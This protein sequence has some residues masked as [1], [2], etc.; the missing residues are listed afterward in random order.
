MCSVE[1][2]DNVAQA[3]GLSAAKHLEF[4]CAVLDD[5]NSTATVGV[6]AWELKKFYEK[7][8]I[9]LF[10]LIVILL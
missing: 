1:I 4:G 6:I 2:R 10:L 5:I 3:C 8:F 7:Y 9:P